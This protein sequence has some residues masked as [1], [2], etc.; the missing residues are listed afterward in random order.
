MAQFHKYDQVRF[1]IINYIV[2]NNL[3]KGDRLPS[4]QKMAEIF[5]VSSITLRRALSDFERENIIEK[6]HGSG[7]FLKKKLTKNLCLEKITFIEI[8]DSPTCSSASHV[9]FMQ[10]QLAGFGLHLQNISCAKPGRHVVEQV[11]DSIGIFV[12]GWLTKEWYDFLALFKM[13][14]VIIGSHPNKNGIVTVKYNWR[15][16]AELQVRNFHSLGYEH[17][18][19][20]NGA[21]SYYPSVEIFEG[22]QS[23][24][25]KTGLPCN[26]NSF[27]WTS[28]ETIYQEIEDFLKTETNLDAILIE[29]G[30][31][32]PFFTCFWNN[33]Y[34]NKPCIGIAGIPEEDWQ[35]RRSKLNSNRIVQVVFR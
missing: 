12:S 16:A 7:A 3:D 34:P 14:V 13:P 20:I 17:I 6:K 33:D 10:E 21:K 15:K 25:K 35:E 28:P 5:N 11:E 9:P 27:I 2:S 22:Y 24:L 29:V 4:E 32:L 19:L 18:G 30:I 23:E 26:K 1:D 31:R 8:I